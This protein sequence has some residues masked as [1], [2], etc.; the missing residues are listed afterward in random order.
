MAVRLGYCFFLD[1]RDQ[2]VISVKKI[3]LQWR[4]FSTVITS[5]GTFS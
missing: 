2:I 4:K 5:G 1:R 3:R